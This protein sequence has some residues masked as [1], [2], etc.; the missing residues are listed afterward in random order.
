[1]TQKVSVAVIG[2]INLDIVAQVENFPQPGETVT[3]AVVHRFP[4]GKGA[5]QAIAAHRSGCFSFHGGQ[6]G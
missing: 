1:M 5:N 3:N 6:S 4:G 2:S